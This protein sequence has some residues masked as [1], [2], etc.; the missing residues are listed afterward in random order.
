MTR[1]FGGIGL[2]LA[3]TN[4]L[5]ALMGSDLKIESQPGQG[6]TFSFTVEFALNLN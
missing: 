4:D 3:V 1:R 5:L 6:S 2:G